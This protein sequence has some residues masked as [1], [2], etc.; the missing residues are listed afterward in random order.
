MSGTNEL[1]VAS[2]ID[3]PSSAIPNQNTELNVQ[4]NA[5]YIRGMVAELRNLCIG[6][7][8]ALLRYFLSMT[9]EEADNHCSIKLAPK[10]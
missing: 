3:V 5:E 1:N 9:F 10:N 6:E 2:E 4:G 7:D 8:L